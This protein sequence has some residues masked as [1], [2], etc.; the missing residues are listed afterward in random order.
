MSNMVDGV[1]FNRLHRAVRFG[2]LALGGFFV[3]GHGAAQAQ[4]FSAEIVREGGG[5]TVPAG[6]LRV[7][8]GR[9]RIETPQFAD[10]FFLAD[11]A[12]RSAY[13]VRP[14]A[15]VYMDARQSSRLTRLFVS[16]DPDEPCRQWQAMA[17]VAG[18]VDEGDW[19]CERNGE[20]AIDG[21]NTTVFRAV[22]G[23]GQGYAGWI[24]RERKFPLRIKTDDGTVLTVEHIKD[25]PQSASSF[26][27]P[28]NARKF[29]PQALIERIKQSDVWVNEEKDS[30]S[31][32]P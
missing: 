20:E 3:G 27:L 32:S 1:T 26:E 18:V 5:A 13:F 28:S 8:D 23:S 17:R 19:R 6:K 15:R 12:K 10:G 31:P 16:V 29:N 14:G 21:R 24:D 7:L 25:E 9:V 2:L 30:G 11:A 22:S 4:Q